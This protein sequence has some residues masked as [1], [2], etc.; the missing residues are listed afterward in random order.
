MRHSFYFILCLAALSVT[1]P[2]CVGDQIPPKGVTFYPVPVPVE[3]PEPELPAPPTAED[4]ATF[5]RNASLEGTWQLIREEFQ[6]GFETDSINYRDSAI[7]YTFTVD[8]WSL[9]GV[10]YEINSLRQKGKQIIRRGDLEAES[11]PYEYFYVNYN[12]PLTLFLDYD[13]VPNIQSGDSTLY[14]LRGYPGFMSL[15]AVQINSENGHRRTST[16]RLIFSKVE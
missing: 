2:G 7:F 16:P 15:C 9:S 8:E 13:F 14:C 1:V 4:T 10:I 6:V 3:E 5:V 12:D 11:I